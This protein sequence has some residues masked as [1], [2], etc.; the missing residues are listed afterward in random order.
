MR[1]QAAVTQ[2]SNPYQAGL[3]LGDVLRASSPDLVFIFGT[4]QYA[5]SSALVEGLYDAI[6]RPDLVIVGN[7]GDGFYAP[8]EFSDV[9]ASALGLAF[10]AG[11]MLHLTSATGVAKDT[12]GTV[13]RAFEELE[14]S[15][16]GATPSIVFFQADAR[17]N[18]VE[19]ETMVSNDRRW[20]VVG[21][22][23][24]DY[25]GLTKGV[26]FA[27]R[28]RIVDGV[29][30][31]AIVGPD[32]C[33]IE[34]ANRFEFLCEPA[35]V[36]DATGTVV[37]TIAGERAVD[38]V[39]RTTGQ[40]LLLPSSAVAVLSI[41][42]DESKDER[43]TR[44]IVAAY[45]DSVRAVTL[46]GKIESGERI[47]VCRVDPGR[48]VED[49]RDLGKAVRARGDQPVAGLIV[50][51]SGRKWSLRDRIG[52]EVGALVDGL[53]RIPLAGFPSFAEILPVRDPNAPGSLAV[54]NMT[55]VLL[56]FGT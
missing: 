34:V 25:H 35:L 16:A 53:G 38:F 29:A 4:G 52:E 19:L 39:E 50:S 41:V 7:A 27:N 48:L 26:I 6:D 10:S 43:R 1:A 44:G 17:A 46:Y 18:S 13:R 45:D 51:C 9:G 31:L 49:V 15:L 54:H 8:E 21:G 24:S 23:V 2:Q 5:E 33:S 3:E 55:Y 11:T 28:A 36:D 20:P 12:A 37:R 32:R 56:L 42:D 30:A 14:A 40:P 22:L 47:Q